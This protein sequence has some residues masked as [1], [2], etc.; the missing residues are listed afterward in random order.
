M[1]HVE[2]RG[3]QFADGVYEV[4]EILGGRLVDERRHLDRLARSLAEMRIAAPMPEAALR[5]VL[6]E[7]LR[8]NRLREGALYL[9]ITRG[10]ARRDHVFPDPPVAPA[11]VVTA[12]HLDRSKA[13][14]VAEQG[15]GIITLPEERWARVDIKTVGL[16]ANVLAKQRAKEAGAREAWFVDRDGFVTEGGSTNAWIVRADG[17]LLTRPADHDILRGVTRTTVF[18]L[19]RAEGLR[20]VERPFSVAEAL[21]AREAFVTAATALVLPVVRIDGAPVG[22]GRPGPVAR[23]LRA[24]FHDFAERSAG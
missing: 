10:V 17:V 4:I 19:A 11:I 13:E 22:D 5:V 15:V 23:R 3:Y 20:I 18:D 2:D 9:Q 1:V 24:R 21:A 16:T 12:R 14:A 7:T 6:R 8:R